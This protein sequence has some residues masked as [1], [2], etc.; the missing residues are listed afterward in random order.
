LNSRRKGKT[1]C[2]LEQDW[3]YN[4]Q[5]NGYFEKLFH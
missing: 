1:P 4:L 5:R 3:T 2:A